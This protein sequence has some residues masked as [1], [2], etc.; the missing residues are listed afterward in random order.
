L[1]NPGLS[2]FAPVVVV[3]VVVVVVVLILVVL[4]LAAAAEGV[5][6]VLGG[7]NGSTRDCNN[8]EVGRGGQ[9]VGNILFRFSSPHTNEHCDVQQCDTE[10]PS[11]A[12]ARHTAWLS[13]QYRFKGYA[14]L[15]NLAG[16][17]FR[18]AVFCGVDY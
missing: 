16:V 11:L 9:D 13:L 2:V 1:D 17:A 10:F 3:I 15:W 8:G 4:L 14:L 5:T 6:V 12:L 7:G 18:K